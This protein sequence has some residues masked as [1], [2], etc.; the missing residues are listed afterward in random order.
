M[1]KRFEYM[2]WTIEFLPVGNDVMINA[3][4]MAKPFV[5]KVDV[6]LQNEQTQRFI[7]ACLKSE[8]SRFLGIEKAE[9]LFTSKYQSGVFM[10]RILAL[11]F[12][13]WL[14]P[15]FEVW[16][17]AT[18]DKFMN[19]IYRKQKEALIEKLMAKQKKQLKK[20]ELL[21]KYADNADIMEYFSLERAERLAHKKRMLINQK[22]REQ[23]RLHLGLE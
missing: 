15:A 1:I 22:Q 3:S 8:D 12:A 17:F 10:H 2:H 18:I 23:L 11:K 4:E 20:L 21:E 7:N 9:D 16:A 14:S 19:E 13:A 5:K 6:F